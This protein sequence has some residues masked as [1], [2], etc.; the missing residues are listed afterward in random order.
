[1]FLT[2][3]DFVPMSLG[4]LM[5]PF[6]KLMNYGWFTIRPHPFCGFATVLINT[7]TINSVPITRYFNIYKFYKMCH[8]DINRYLT[9]SIGML[10]ADRSVWFNNSHRYVTRRFVSLWHFTRFLNW[11]I[12]N[13]QSIKEEDTRMCP[14][15]GYTPAGYEVPHKQ[16]SR[17]RARSF[18]HSHSNYLCT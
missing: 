11:R 2:P 10:S 7:D 9:K 1:M 5:E 4:S 17:A 15:V 12:L 8:R 14:T 3:T 16:E 18:H 6:L 13:G